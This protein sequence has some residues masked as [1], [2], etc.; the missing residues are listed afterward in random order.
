MDYVG[1]DP[2][3]YRQVIEKDTTEG[4]QKFYMQ[5]LGGV[6]SYIRFPSLFDREDFTKYAIN[7]A[8]LVITD[9]DPE[10]MFAQ[11]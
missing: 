4:E 9:I 7:E 6:D 1:S 2:D 11:A 10:S 5:T 8:K 3:F